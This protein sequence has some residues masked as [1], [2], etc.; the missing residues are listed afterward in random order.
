MH[1]RRSMLGFVFSIAPL[2]IGC[3]GGEEA[4]TSGDSSSISTTESGGGTTGTGGA[5]STGGSGGTG[6][7]TT[8]E[9]EDKAAN[10]V[11]GEEDLGQSLTSA[12]GR[13]DGTVLAVV[14]P[15]DTECYLPNDDHVVLQVLWNGE[16][17]RMV[18]NVKSSFGDPDVFYLVSDKMPE[19]LVW[20]EG[21]HPDVTLDYVNDLGI[22]TGVF[23][24]YPML[25]LSDKIAD[26]ITLGQKVSVFAES[27][28][29]PSSAH[30]IHR[31]GGGKDGAIVIDPDSAAPRTLLFHF[32]DQ[33]F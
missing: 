9:P 11:D 18:I 5:S 17:Y 13:L 30:N 21:W 24:Q 16:A 33:S 12:F 8:T 7:S 19:G 4:S 20:E 31:N 29:Y 1:H 15:T 22:H 2:F 10:C 3:D 23:T 26:E 28:G 25:E 6:G 32:S 27:D 14:K